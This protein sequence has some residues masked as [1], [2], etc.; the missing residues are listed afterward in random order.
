[1][2]FHVSLKDLED[3]EGRILSGGS[4][5]EIVQR[6]RHVCEFLPVKTIISIADGVVS[7]DIP[8]CVI[9]NKL[10]A[11]R[12]HERASQR[13]KS[14]EYTKAISIWER[15]LELD[16]TYVLARRVILSTFH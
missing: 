4:N 8:D 14:G 3:I 13:A 15:V 2:H 10:E 6:L 9:A 5:D 11:I 7:I 1:M 16:P 12:P